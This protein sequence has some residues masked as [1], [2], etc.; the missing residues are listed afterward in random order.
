M[1][2]IA[3]FIFAILIPLSVM[4]APQY[5]G[6]IK[7]FYLNSSGTYLVKF[8]TPTPEC[9]NSWPFRYHNSSESATGWTSML[10]TARTMNKT[11]RVGYSPDSSGS[12]SVAYFYFMD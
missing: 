4:G 11:I 3:C 2:K 1:K 12:C 10:L 5:Q 9:P 7:G 8:D 6:K